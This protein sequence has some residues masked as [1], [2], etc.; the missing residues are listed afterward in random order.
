M[1]AALPDTQHSTTP[2]G[3]AVLMKAIGERFSLKIPGP[4]G[5]GATAGTCEVNAWPS[6]EGFVLRE[7]P[8]FKCFSSPYSDRLLGSSRSYTMSNPSQLF[9]A[10]RLRLV[11]N[12]YS[13]GWAPTPAHFGPDRFRRW[14]L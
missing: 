2:L 5:P 7:R 8:A 9:T 12:K 11:L 6:R 10:A 4:S 1:G 3:Y 13:I 14:P